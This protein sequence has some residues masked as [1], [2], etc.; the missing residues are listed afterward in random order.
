MCCSMLQCVL[1][2]IAVHRRVLQFLLPSAV[3]EA[4]IRSHVRKRVD[5][6]CMCVTHYIDVCW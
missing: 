4:M 6:T 3:F 1:Q 5:V 2:C